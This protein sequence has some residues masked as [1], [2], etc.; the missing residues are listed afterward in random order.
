MR[1]SDLSLESISLECGFSSYANFYKAFRAEKG[2][3]PGEVLKR[4]R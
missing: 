2:E 1:Y 4:M 3:N